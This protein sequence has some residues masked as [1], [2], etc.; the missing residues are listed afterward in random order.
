MQFNSI[1]K[2]QDFMNKKYFI[3]GD[4]I[5]KYGLIYFDRRNQSKLAKPNF[6]GLSDRVIFPIKDHKSGI[7]AGLHCRHVLYKKE[8]GKSKQWGK[9]SNVVDYGNSKLKTTDISIA[10]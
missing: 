8:E 9:Y 1:D 7:V 2:L 5:E 4:I 3:S 6:Y 10:V